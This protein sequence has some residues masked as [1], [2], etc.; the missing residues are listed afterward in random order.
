MPL[1]GFAAREPS[2]GRRRKLLKRARACYNPFVM[3]GQFRDSEALSGEALS[4]V[5]QRERAGPN[6]AGSF[7]CSAAEHFVNLS[8][9]VD[10]AD[11]VAEFRR[12]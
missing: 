5:T 3:P 7:L 8:D 6:K 12:G 2:C 11:A 9:G 10:E 4:A 1:T